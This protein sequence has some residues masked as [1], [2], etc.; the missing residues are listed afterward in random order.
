MAVLAITTGATM[1]SGCAA[2]G[3]Q[4]NGNIKQEIVE[5]CSLLDD[6]RSKCIEKIDIC[7]AIQD[8]NKLNETKKQKECL[9]R[10][11]DEIKGNV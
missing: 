1:M 10:V 7:E 4:T 2:I 8:D 6:G 5:S 3:I 9:R 11:R